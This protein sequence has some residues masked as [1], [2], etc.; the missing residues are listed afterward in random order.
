MAENPARVLIISDNEDLARFFLEEFRRPEIAALARAELRYSSINRQ[1]SRLAA[2][3]ATPVNLTRAEEV[4]AILEG[5]DLVISAHCKK[6]FPPELVNN[7][8]CVNFHPGFNPHNRGWYPQVFGLL[9][10]Q[11]LGATVHEMTEEIDGG[12]I[13][14]RQRVELDPADTSG[15]AYAKVIEAEKALIREWLA[16]VVT[17][18]YTPFPAE[19]AGNYNGIADFRALLELDLDRQGSLGEHLDLLRALSHPPFWNAWFR[20]ADGSKVF[21]RLEL[22]KEEDR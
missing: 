11:P 7:V 5:F 12:P 6:I 1:P 3:G 2:L 14:A 17:G 4:E 16:P 19:S 22:R 20:G 13:I 9:N 18:D 8:R 10:G 21:V 15:S